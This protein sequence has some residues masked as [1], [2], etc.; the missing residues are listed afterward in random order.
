MR[1]GWFVHVTLAI[2]LSGAAYAADPPRRKP[3]DPSQRATLLDLISAVDAAAGRGADVEV[4]LAWDHHV[5]K[6]RDQT[7]YVPFRLTLDGAADA[8]TSTA[9]ILPWNSR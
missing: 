2:V 9:M 3:L 5:L 6:S 8:F 1:S 7:A 4:A